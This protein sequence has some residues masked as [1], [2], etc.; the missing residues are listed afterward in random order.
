MQGE[1]DSKFWAQ[2]IPLLS[3]TQ[4]KTLLQ[5]RRSMKWMTGNEQVLDLV[6]TEIHKREKGPED[7]GPDF[8]S[9][10]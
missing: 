3:L 2:K 1:F 5:S 9:A 7:S 8:D 10:S 6:E 4:L